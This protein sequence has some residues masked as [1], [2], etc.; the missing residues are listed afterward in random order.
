MSV[1]KDI[2]TDIETVLISNAPFEYA[3]LIKFERPNAPDNLGFRTNANRYAYFTD[4]S[5]DISFDDGSTDQDG[6]AN[7]AQIYR[8]NR[9][10]SLGSY[11]ETIQAKSTTMNL[12]LGAEHLNTSVSI[13]AQFSTNGTFA[14]Q[15]GFTTEVFDFVE[16]GFREGDLVSISRNSG[17]V[18]T[19]G[20]NST[21][22][23]KYIITGFSNSNQTLT[24]AK[25]GNDNSTGFFDIGFP[26]S[27]ITEA[28]TI[29]L[30]SDE[31]RGVL[32][33]ESND[34][35]SPTFFNREVFVYKIFIDPETGDVH[36]VND[37]NS[38]NGILT[39][40]GIISSCTLNEKS[41]G[42]TVSWALTSHWGDFNEIRGRITSDSAQRGLNAEE[43]PNPLQ[44]LRPA[45][46][47]DLG[48]LHAETSLATLAEYQRIEK[49]RNFRSVSSRAGGLRGIFGGKNYGIEEYE[50]EIVHNE[51][52]NL[53]IGMKAAS[54]PLVYGVRKIE[55]IPVFADTDKND[56][57]K[58]FVVYALAEGE[59]HGVFNAHI[60]DTSII[61][62][63]ET[64][65]LTRNAN[66]GTNKDDSKM[67]C[68]GR[69]SR[70]DTLGGVDIFTV[71]TN[72]TTVEND[73]NQ[74]YKPD[75][76][77][78]GS[79]NQIEPQIDIPVIS[80][81]GTTPIGFDGGTA[82]APVVNTI[83]SSAFDQSNS[84]VGNAD[85]LQHREN[86]NFKAVFGDDFDFAIS[87]MR[88]IEDQSALSKLV[89]L[90]KTNDFKRQSDFYTGN[91]PYW[92]PNHRLL[93]TAYVLTEYNINE[94]MTELPE[95]EYTVKGK[96]YE[97][98]NYDN[99][100]VPDPATSQNGDTL[101][102]YENDTVGVEV[103]YNGGSSYETAKTSSGGTQFRVMDRYEVTD[104]LGNES[105]RFRLD[106]APFFRVDGSTLVAPNGRPLYDKIRINK[107]GAGNWTML[108]WNAGVVRTPTA[109]PDQR[110]NA[111]SLSF[112]NDKLTVTVASLGNLTGTNQVQMVS[113]T[114]GDDIGG[115]LENFKHG[116]FTVS[117]SGNTLTFTNSR[118]FTASIST[119]T[120][121]ALQNSKIFDFS[122]VSA[123]SSLTNANQIVGQFLKIEETG[124]RRKI[125]AFN[126]ST[127][128]VTIETP[129]MFAPLPIHTFTITGSGS[130]LRAGNNP[131]MQLLDY[132]TNRI[133][134]KGL[135]LNTDMDLSS[136][137]TSARLC[138]V[139]SDV[140]IKLTG[141]TPTIGNRYVF[142]PGNVTGCNPPF[143][144]KVKSF[145]STTNLVTFTE[146]TGKLYHLH[147][148]YRTYEK[149][150]VILE[151]NPPSGASG[152]AGFYQFTQA[153]PSTLTSSPAQE[154]NEGSFVAPLSGGANLT[155]TDG[156]TT[157]TFDKSFSA[158]YELYDSDF[159]KYWRYLGW[160]HHHQRWVTRHQT[161]F[162]L[163]TSKSVFANVNM[164]L[165]HFNGFLSY[166]KGQYV[167]DIETQVSAPV[168]AN[169]FNGTTYKENINPYFIEHSDIIGDI[170]LTDN[171]NKNSKNV[172]KASIPDPAIHFEG[173]SV[174]FLNDKYLEGDRN[175]RKT[176]SL[177]FSG[178]T[179]YF[180]GRINAEKA[181]TET[182]YQK[183]ISFR[184]GQKG[185]LIKPGQVFGLT[186]EPFGFVNKLFRIINLNF[187][188]DCT[189][190][191]KAIEYDDSP[192][193][194]SKQR[195]AAIYSQDSGVDSTI[196]APGAPTNLTVSSSKPG[197][198]AISWTNATNFKE[199]TDSTEIY[200]STSNLNNAVLIATVDNATSA[201]F[202]IGEFSNRNFWVRHKRIHTSVTNGRRVLHSA[203]A[204]N[205][206][207]GVAG[208]SKLL[209]P[210]F[211]FDRQNLTIN[212]DGSAA[213]DPSG[214]GQDTTFTVTKRNL[215][216]TPTIQLLDADGTARS[217]NGAFTD[218]SVS[219]NGVSAT[220]DASTF[221][222]TDTPKIVKATLTEGGETFTAIATIGIIKQGIAGTAGI[223]TTTGA[224]YFS[225]DSATSPGAVDADNN[226]VFTF[227]T[228]AFTGLDSGTTSYGATGTWQK[229]P[230]EADPGDTTPKYWLADFTAVENSAG[231]GISSGS[232]L[233]F[234]TPS[235]FINF[236]DVVVFTDLSTSGTT[237]ING[238]NIT[239]GTIKAINLESTNFAQNSNTSAVV[240]SRINLA[241]GQID[242]KQFSIDS[243]GNATF[244][245]NVTA[246]GTI[247]AN[248][249]T[250]GN[251]SATRISGGTF[252]GSNMTMTNINAASI[253][254]GTL[255]VQDKSVVSTTGFVGTTTLQLTNPATQPGYLYST[256]TNTN[257]WFQSFGAASPF[258]RDASGVHFNQQITDG[259]GLT[260]RLPAL[261]R[262][263]VQFNFRPEFSGTYSFIFGFEFFGQAGQHRTCASVTS[264]SEN[265]SFFDS[266]ITN[267]NQNQSDAVV[268]V[269]ADFLHTRAR[270]FTLTANKYHVFNTFAFMH[271]I[272]KF[273]TQIPSV[274][275][276]ISSTN[277][278][279]A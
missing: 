57:R 186:Y 199:V 264:F 260:Y 36:G 189:V 251:L 68:F 139:R 132:M 240:G 104:R 78:G 27:N 213:L 209:D 126:T 153:T 168:S 125:T 20:T 114:A 160:E 250:A 152:A 269:N 120:P 246:N 239:T 235:T 106:V 272:F 254:T 176:Q 42:S 190:T 108:P 63:D 201:E 208:V 9:I 180:N 79:L 195:R 34:L 81:E 237:T 61:C 41:K 55:G 4:A 94:E 244:E 17:T 224:V 222:S 32:A 185:L 171:S 69:M 71:N 156:S 188:A 154:F 191:I 210:S 101:P 144:G 67:V 109:F 203:Y 49:R 228:G 29:T 157:L 43:K 54:I 252:N 266:S 220:I 198:F 155:L 33:I 28:F 145:N 103:S 1:K 270:E 170:K 263:I 179:N 184:V 147:N 39:F 259:S 167:L 234:G 24:L 142:N 118:N 100:Y 146:C 35:A 133:Y 74:S 182:R 279:K 192:Y 249:I 19:D 83:E 256:S 178:I 6:N 92:S 119:D 221:V 245:G 151:T 70:G 134:G 7:G 99:T 85:G 38:I 93:D 84:T 62:V 77:V 164:M 175:V 22:S 18:I 3:H 205:N 215:S 129:F 141:G 123:I 65:F 5:R 278:R 82:S 88:G 66:T 174:T 46:A 56:A 110:V 138:D 89:A 75:P 158:R 216:G 143:S 204:P 219:I 196:K 90:A 25:T 16:Q 267:T 21:S 172:V 218:G 202:L 45:H 86:V 137:I 12:V 96:V 276:F 200:A 60:D 238:D 161:N 116:A 72:S 10:K 187:Q 112:S 87:F 98:Y 248:A 115:N 102:I 111:S 265:T 253:S 258:H 212:F 261:L 255:R 232:N 15:S 30:E 121:V 50:E 181:L 226:A 44:A 231:A 48:F 14:Y 113:Q 52:V 40:K 149:G 76:T 130:D 169:T 268:G 173:R 140:T 214:T 80:L 26:S 241:N 242:S 247:N 122:S 127:N 105:Y 131:A 124:E 277:F 51:K 150:D 211:G 37:T 107:I 53:D 59:M 166:E 243:S 225:L 177:A 128:K 207:S 117:I 271:D 262:P 274:R 193:I 58:I 165:A 47:A 230:P 163:D 236:T 148:N 31:L 73:D 197:F 194:I 183:E 162:L 23:A 229:T 135:D 64:D 2:N 8:A 97:N 159:I 257:I 136:F 233:T 13:T 223:R 227:G 217:G 11:S 91:L 95:L 275:A 206:T 273:G